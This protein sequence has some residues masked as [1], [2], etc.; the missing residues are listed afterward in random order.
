MNLFKTR[1]PEEPQ[2]IEVSG[3]Q[4]RCPICSNTLFWTRQAQLNTAVAT[5]FNM[6]WVNK[7]AS[8]FICSDCTHIS[9]F[10][11]GQ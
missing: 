7:S 2:A 4:L 5:F 3:R 8:C 1:Q 6:D 11:G 9:W 10:L